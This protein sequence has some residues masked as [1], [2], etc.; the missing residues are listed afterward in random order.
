[1]KLLYIDASLAGISGNML[2]GALLD[3]GASEKKLQRV[4]NA[5]SKKLG[6]RITIAKKRIEKYHMQA[7][8]VDAKVARNNSQNLISDLRSLADGLKLSK[9]AREFATAVGETILDAEAKA[10]R[11]SREKLHLH[12]LGSADTLLDILGCAAL[13]ED[14]DLFSAAIYSSP[15]NA[16]SGSEGTPAPPPAVVEM[17]KRY[18]I[19]FKMSHA[20]RELATPTGVALL[21]NLAAFEEPPVFKLKASGAG[22]GSFELPFPNVLRLM[23]GEVQNEKEKISVLE[24][25]VDDVSGEV[26]GYALERLYEE[27]ALDVQILAST[28]KKSRPAYVL[29]VLCR[30]GN[31]EKLA[32]TLMRETGTLGVRISGTSRFH[33]GRETKT[34]EVAIA[35]HR[36]KAKVK[37]AYD[38]KGKIVNLK[39]EYEDA[40]KIAR[41]TKQPLREVFKEIE[42]AARKQLK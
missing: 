31:E 1:M 27:G 35:R 30:S 32:E 25:N 37:A 3:L 5:I 28:T 33:L 22:A 38:A 20:G 40:A 34:V 17:F 23:L 39:P 18:K 16:G 4:A 10:H 26:L 19:P 41:K 6:C 2:L 29:S 36:V 11:T 9:Q 7:V 14:L 13:L 12:E 24:T 15:I 42:S 8:L 21:A